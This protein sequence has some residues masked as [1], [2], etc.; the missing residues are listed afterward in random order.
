M[1]AVRCTVP[2]RLAV[3]TAVVALLTTPVVSQAL[4]VFTGSGFTQPGSVSGHDL[5]WVGN[6]LGTPGSLQVSAGSTPIFGA[7]MLGWNQADGQALIEGVGTSLTLDHNGNRL[8]VGHWGTAELMVSNGAKLLADGNDANCNGGCGGSMGSFAGTTSE[9]VIRDAGSEVR[10]RDSFTMSAGSVNT[11]NGWG[12]EGGHTATRLSVLDGGQF[13]SA[14]GGSGAG[15]NNRP[16]E[17][18]SARILVSGAGARWT[19]G[20]GSNTIAANRGP[21]FSLSTSANNQSFLDVVA[22]GEMVFNGNASAFSGINAGLNGGSARINVSGVGSK[23]QFNGESGV[24]QVARSAGAQSSMVV[25]DG[26][27]VLGLYYASIGRD[28]GT[29]SLL[30]DGAGSL[31]ALTGTTNAATN[32]GTASVAS[33]DIGRAAGANGSVTVSNGGRIEI[34]ATAA[35][36]N[37]PSLNVG[38]RSNAET[39]VGTGVLNISG[40]NAVVQLSA[41]SVLAGGGVAEAINPTVNIGRFGTGALNIT[42]GGKLLLQGDAVSTVA[43]SRSTVIRI[44]GAGDGA[45]GGTGVALL[46]GLGSEIALSGS[47]AFFAV[48]QGAGAIGSLTVADQAVLRGTV[49]AVGRSGGVGTLAVSGGSVLLSGQHT[50]N[51][52][53]GAGISVGA[54]GGTGVLTMANNALLRIDNA[55]GNVSAGMSIGG[56][57]I[58]PGG[59]G[60][61]TLASGSRIEVASPAGLGGITVGREGVGQLS[62]SASSIDVGATGAVILGRNAGS[63]GGL[64]MAGN[65]TLAAQYVGVGRLRN[66]DG[67]TTVNGGVASLIVN[68]GSVLTAQTVEIG[69]AGYLGGTG[70]IVGNVINHGTFNPG[71][72]PG[73]FTIDGDFTAAAGSKLVLEVESDGAGGFVTDKLIFGS[74]HVVDLSH[75]AVEFRFL[76]DTNPNDFKAQ[77]LFDVDTFFR[78]QVAGGGTADLAPAA[79]SSA[80][81][82]AQA[83]GY[84]ISQFN[85][86]AANGADFTAVPVPEPGT[87]LMLAA[88]L[89]VVGG[90]LRRRRLPAR[91]A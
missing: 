50:G 65:S 31:L 57:N 69:S 43:A 9:L 39:T 46:S 77:Q 24:L 30:V 58:F 47:D 64:L 23:M 55:A 36:S 54:G 91:G 14:G 72:S 16:G 85:F 1:P 10:L 76:G 84:A 18:S 27:A 86:S 89:V 20:A 44:G 28:G 78:V 80:T 17:S 71:N 66:S 74:Y 56:S 33:L 12:T 48:G 41:A 53:S 90:V 45:S 67:S 75:L 37:G 62:M 70:S 13:F 83:D 8:S 61:V 73:V 38:T 29:G 6:G 81:F 60:I 34:T 51:N 35:R 22:G 5:Q 3:T 19:L 63:V 32:A 15:N 59:Q 40:S 25:K 21:F 42:G 7:L 2:R 26:G 52:L 49:I 11:A 79:F 87:G 68:S 82:S 88:G 4:V